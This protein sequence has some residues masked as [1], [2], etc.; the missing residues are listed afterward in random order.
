MNIT[1]LQ[2]I[3]GVLLLLI[4][5]YVLYVFSL[6][7]LTKVLRAMLKMVV[8]M[9]ILGGI[10]YEVILLNHIAVTLLCGFLMIVMGT[11]FTIMRAKLKLRQL[12]LPVLVGTLAGVLVLGLYLSLLVVGQSNP[13]EARYF[14]PIVGLLVGNLIQVNSKALHIY[15]MGLLHHA[16][17]YYYL[18]GNG[19][20]HR[21]ALN[22][23]LKRT[24][25]QAALPHI[26]NMGLMLMGASPIILWSMVL[27]GVSVWVA[28]AYQV[29]LLIAMFATSI[30]SIWITVMVSRK[31]LLDDYCKLKGEKRHEIQG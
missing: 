27:S 30:L 15:Y 3:W 16:Q 5:C 25:E 28:I 7:L 20:T 6:K 22:Y 19:F 23:L 29:C 12:F 18:L 14:V 9:V 13:L 10:V 24:I 8:G 17:L 21:Y 4:P 1:L 26:S 31:Y 2:C 11:F